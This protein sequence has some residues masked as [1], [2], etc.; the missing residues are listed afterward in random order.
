MGERATGSGHHR[1]LKVSCERECIFNVTSMPMVQ[2][3]VS[4]LRT[5][6]CEVDLTRHI[7]CDMCQSGSRIEHAGGYDPA[8]N[9]VFV[10]CNN[11][12]N[13]GLVHGALVRN[14]IQMFDNCVNK[15]NFNDVRHLACSEVRKAN[16][17]NCQ[18]LT[19]LTRPD[20]NFAVFG[21]HRKCVRSVAVEALVKTKFVKE[22]V[23]GKVVDEVFDKCYA[24]LEPI[25]RRARNADDIQRAENEKFLF[26][27]T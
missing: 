14:L 20:A 11:A 5:A 27:Y 18:F 16:L 1:S 3:M 19:S 4:A 15:Y 17:A 9:Q 21:Q 7:S 8:L 25:G 6:G 22:E 2:H 24:D 12:T 23:A 13:S 26:G 10:C